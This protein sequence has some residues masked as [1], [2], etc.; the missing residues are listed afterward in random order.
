M[1]AI[2]GLGNPGLRYKFTR[3]NVGFLTVKSLARQLRIR[4]GLRE[5]NCFLGKG[6]MG[7]EKVILGLPLTYMNLSGQAVAPVLKRHRVELAD[8]LIICDDVNLPL[9]KVRIR[10]KGSDGGHKGLRSIIQ[11]LDSQ[12]FPRLRIGVG[13]PA[14]KSQEDNLRK[15]VLARFTKKETKLIEESIAQAREAVWVW[16]REGI[17]PAMN[18]FN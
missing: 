12:D 17:V 9:G 14:E 13:S 15:Y 11:N 18:K 4:L 7:G 16:A 1:K 3:H 6:T 10:A 2:I 5:F 8:A